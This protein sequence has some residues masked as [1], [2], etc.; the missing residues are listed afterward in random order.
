MLCS[1]I[2]LGKDVR[3]CGREVYNF[4]ECA[5]GRP[6]LPETLEQKPE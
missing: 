2:H 1:K 3:E 4:T 6:L 5:Q